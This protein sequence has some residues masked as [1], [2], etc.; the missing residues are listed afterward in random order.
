MYFF[1]N[2]ISCLKN[3]IQHLVTSEQ[4]KVTFVLTAFNVNKKVLT[5]V[6][7]K[8]LEIGLTFVPMP[9]MINEANLKRDFDEFGR[10]IRCK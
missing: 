8:V 4:K 9:N 10:K 1:Q 2:R 5:P 7:I 6:E 3:E